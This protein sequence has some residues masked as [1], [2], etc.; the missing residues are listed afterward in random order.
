MKLVICTFFFCLSSLFG[1]TVQISPDL[2]RSGPLDNPSCEAVLMVV[3]GFILNELISEFLLLLPFLLLSPS[4]LLYFSLLSPPPSTVL[5]H[6]PINV[7]HIFENKLESTQKQLSY[8]ISIF[9]SNPL[10]IIYLGTYFGL[11]S[12]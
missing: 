2:E 5:H 12:A 4:F 10:S 3:V 11:I 1:C 9:K 6:P 8:L 7:G